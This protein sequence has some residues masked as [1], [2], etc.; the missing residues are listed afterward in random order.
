M[1][2]E[3]GIVIRIDKGRAW[4]K[5]IRSGACEA[6]SSRGACHSFG[7]RKE[8]EVEALNDVGA[9]AGDQVQICFDTGKLMSISFLYVFPVLML[10]AGAVIGQTMASFY[11]L[12]ESLASALAGFIFFGLAFLVI[13][14]A[15]SALAGKREYQPRIAKVVAKR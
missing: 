1:A 12:S 11:Q 6:C 15:G 5:T 10:I 9:I 4:I 13:R 14:W 3:E 7:D 2:T 8:M